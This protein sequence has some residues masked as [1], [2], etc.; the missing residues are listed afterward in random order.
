MRARAAA[1]ALL[2]AITNLASAGQ[3]ATLDDGRKVLLTD[4]GRW[5]YL[6]ADEGSL[7]Q[8]ATAALTVERVESIPQGCR[9]GLQLDNTLTTPIRS[10]VLRFTAYKSGPVAYETQTRGF[11]LIKPTDNQ[12]R[13]ILFRD[14]SCDNIAQVQ[15]HGAKNCHVGDLTKYTDGQ[16]KCLSLIKV[17]DSGLIKIYK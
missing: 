13:E 17:V 7:G 10:L 9:I 14:V 11:S 4:D 6:T 16:D 3:Q 5:E 2:W 12:Y 8:Q 15:V 1:F